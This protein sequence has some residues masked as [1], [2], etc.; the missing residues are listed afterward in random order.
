MILH[1]CL[2]PILLFQFYLYLFFYS[3]LIPIYSFIPVL[4]LFILLFIVL[5]PNLSLIF[6][7]YAADKV[8]SS[9]FLYSIFV[10]L[11]FKFSNRLFNFIILLSPLPFFHIY[12]FFSLIFQYSFFLSLTLSTFN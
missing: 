6:I 5:F 2:Y 11:T 7:L 1:Y 12:L 8:L 4:L 3:R 10:G 9:T